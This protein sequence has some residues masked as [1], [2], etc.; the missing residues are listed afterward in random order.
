MILLAV[1]CWI[2][3]AVLFVLTLLG[4]PLRIPVPDR[5]T[6]RWGF[7]GI[8]LLE[9]SGLIDSIAQQHD[10]AKIHRA[11][12]VVELLFTLAALACVAAGAI[13]RR[14]RGRVTAD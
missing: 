1:T 5:P 7:A 9:T 13:A 11:V 10:W 6:V 3:V 12:G 8:L 4:R 14:R 2:V